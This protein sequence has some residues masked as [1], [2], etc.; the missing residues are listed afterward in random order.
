MRQ[1]AKNIMVCSYEG[2]LKLVPEVTIT[3][4]TFETVI[5]GK[6]HR[7]CMPTPS[8]NGQIVS[9]ILSQGHTS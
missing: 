7:W 5:T 4:V 1:F 3:G 2:S 9:G 6:K 8:K